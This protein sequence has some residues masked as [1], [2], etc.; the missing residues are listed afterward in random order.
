MTR[1]TREEMMAAVEKASKADTPDNVKETYKAIVMAAHTG[2]LALSSFIPDG[3]TR[4]YYALITMDDNG[5]VLPLAIVPNHIEI[6]TFI[7]Q[8]DEWMD[9]LGSAESDPDYKGVKM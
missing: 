3:G 4:V 7:K 8:Y 5:Q 2:R 9:V 1:A 6:G